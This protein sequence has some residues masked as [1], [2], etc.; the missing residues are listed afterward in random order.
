M[1]SQINTGEISLS[2]RVRENEV[3]I[4]RLQGGREHFATRADIEKLRADLTWRILLA[5]GVLMGLVMAFIE[6]RVVGEA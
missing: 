6:W 5:M 1:A 2:D 3:R 4:A